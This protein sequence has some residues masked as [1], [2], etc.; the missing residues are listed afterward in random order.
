MSCHKLSLPK[1]KVRLQTS[2]MYR[3]PN[4]YPLLDSPDPSKIQSTV[5]MGLSIYSALGHPGLD[6]SDGK[7]RICAQ[8]DSRRARLPRRTLSVRTSTSGSGAA[9]S[10]SCPDAGEPV[11][12][13]SIL[14]NLCHPNIVRLMEVIGERHATSLL[15]LIR[16]SEPVCLVLSACRGA[17]VRSVKVVGTA[18][19]RMGCPWG[20]GYVLK[21]VLRA[22]AA[23]GRR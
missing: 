18:G 4:I 17:S 6:E 22:C 10:G 11:C 9:A 20:V 2:C 12:E 3:P 23:C 19:G 1:G 7:I 14:R 8:L 5:G 16:P 15:S 21:C 13:I